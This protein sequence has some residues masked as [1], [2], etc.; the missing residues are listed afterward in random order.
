[1]LHDIKAVEGGAEVDTV[2][3][4]LSDKGVVDTST[5]ED[6]SSIIEELKLR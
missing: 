4:H 6:H 5:L 3:N 1:M 2:Q